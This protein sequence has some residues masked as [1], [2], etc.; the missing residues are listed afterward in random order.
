MSI[1]PRILELLSEGPQTTPELCKA[2]GCAQ[3]KVYMRCSKLEQYGFLKS[4]RAKD[5]VGTPRIWRLAR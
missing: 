3:C 5:T 2:L 4:E 1:D